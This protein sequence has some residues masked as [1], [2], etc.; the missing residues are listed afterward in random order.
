MSLTLNHVT[1]GYR[2]QPV[3]RDLTL[4]PVPPGS[5]VAVV[6]PNAVGKSTLLKSIAGLLPARGALALDGQDLTTLSRSRCVRDIGYLP[7]TLPQAIQIGRA[8]V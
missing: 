7:Q 6:G 8:H 1:A 2:R 5:L 4:P 3:F